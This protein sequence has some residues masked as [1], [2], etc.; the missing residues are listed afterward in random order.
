MDRGGV[1]R[2]LAR[3]PLWEPAR[4]GPAVVAC[5]RREGQHGLPAAKSSARCIPACPGSTSG[6]R[7]RRCHH[8]P[9]A[10]PDT[11]DYRT[12]NRTCPPS[13]LP[14]PGSAVPVNENQPTREQSAASPQRARRAGPGS[15]IA[16][17]STNRPSSLAFP[18]PTVHA[19]DQPSPMG[20]RRRWPGWRRAATAGPAASGGRAEPGT[21]AA[22]W[23]WWWR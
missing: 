8:R 6:H 1:T 13:V 16:D 9:Q 12:T 11:S 5:C 10:G 3:R 7:R 4:P 17:G 23:S 15:G 20:T 21:G 2:A 19:L 18:R 22:P 14:G